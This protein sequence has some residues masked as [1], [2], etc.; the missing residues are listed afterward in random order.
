MMMTMMMMVMMMM[1]MTRSV[2][3]LGEDDDDNDEGGTRNYS[4]KDTR[5]LLCDNYIVARHTEAT[6]TMLQ[7]TLRCLWL[8]ALGI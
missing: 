4:T 5:A 7:F 6:Y 1:L 8:I 3:T 2:I